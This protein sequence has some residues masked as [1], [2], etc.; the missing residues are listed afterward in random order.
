MQSIKNILLEESSLQNHFDNQNNNYHEYLANLHLL[1]FEYNINFTILKLAKILTISLI[2]NDKELSKFL[3]HNDRYDLPVILKT[4]ELL[5]SKRKYIQLEK[6]TEKIKDPKKLS[7]HKAI[8]ANLKA[9]NEN[10]EMK[11]T[12]SKIKFIKENWINYLPKEKLEYMALLFPT[13]HWKW[14]IDIMHLK[15]NDFKLEW[16]TKYIFTGEY[17]KNSIIDICL[18][19]NIPNSLFILSNYKLPYTYL[20]IKHKEL[21][22]IPGVKE[23]IGEYTDLSDIIRYWKE[24]D[25]TQNTFITV[26]MRI[27]AGEEIN[28][29]YGELVK[30]IQMLKEETNSSDTTK[31][32]IDELLIVAEKKLNNYK[33]NIESP[34]VV[35]GDASPSMDVAIKTSSIIASMLVKLC[36]AKLHLF[37]NEDEPIL[38]PPKTVNEVLEAIKLFKSSGSTSPASSLYPYYERKEI[39]KTFILVTDEEENTGYKKEDKNVWNNS[40][41]NYFANVFKKYRSEVYPAKLVF[42]SFLKNNKDGQMVSH[43]KEVIPDIS[44][45]IIQ[46]ILNSSKPDLRKLDALLDKL[47]MESNAYETKCTDVVNF[48]EKNKEKIF[49]AELIRNA[50]DGKIVEV[51]VEVEEFDGIITISI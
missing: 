48:L 46:F 8:I 32:L 40:K 6:K 10:I 47:V 36:H 14:L 19:I 15:P 23:I 7:K 31:M 49:N 41:E 28:M 5:D 51:E 27:N 16:F 18:N 29:P 13:K 22:A 12:S 9:L 2:R 1:F 21:L 43:L 45:D 25:T 34:V 3:L 50:L 35:L 39:V 33:I 44:K 11:L 26:H 20:R 4:C 38:N 42:V 30:R 37:R 17:P 24:F